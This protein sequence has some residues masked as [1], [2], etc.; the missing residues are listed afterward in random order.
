MFPKRYSKDIQR[1]A[2]DVAVHPDSVTS[3]FSLQ[4]TRQSKESKTP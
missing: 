4:N 1:E 3:F 2:V